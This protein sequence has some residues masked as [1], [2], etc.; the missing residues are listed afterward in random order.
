[1]PL[2]VAQ[3][4]LE[5]AVAYA[6]ALNL[7]Q[8]VYSGLTVAVTA[9]VWAFT[10]ALAT[11]IFH[12]TFRFLEHLAIAAVS[13]LGI[14][15]LSSL[16]LPTLGF[17]INFPQLSSIGGPIVGG[18]IATMMLGGH[19]A[20]VTNLGPW[21]SRAISLGVVGTFALLFVVNQIA[22]EQKPSSELPVAGVVMPP[23]WLLRQGGSSDALF[24]QLDSLREDVDA[25]REDKR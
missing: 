1:M 7:A 12:G 5:R 4:I 8:Q 19:I 17:A 6:W 13:L 11:R 2:L 20:R 24:S 23:G 16:I 14:A 22:E 18:V 3:P 15:V 25:L 21:K 10:W 9:A